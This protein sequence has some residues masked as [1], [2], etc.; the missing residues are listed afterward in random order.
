MN[1]AAPKRVAALEGEFVTSVSCGRD[2]TLALTRD[3]SLYAWG[4]NDYGQLGLN[5]SVKYQRRPLLVGGALAGR[6][7]VAV[8][9][10]D[11]HAA[12]LCEGGEVFTWG[13]GKEG[14]LG[15]GNRDALAVPRRVEA[16]AGA[17]VTA[18]ACGGGHTAALDGARQLWLFGRGRSGQLGRG[19]QVEST[20]AYRPLPTL[21]AAL[22][23]GG[24]DVD[25][26]GVSLGHDHTLALVKPRK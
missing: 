8:A 15:H 21:V 3:G 7:V 25:V 11:F 23:K 18:V 5:L 10:G 16:L 26:L 17:G 22:A 1:E 14:Q 12:A 4:A 13:L 24:A 9:A 19:D 20:A 6:R 2:Y